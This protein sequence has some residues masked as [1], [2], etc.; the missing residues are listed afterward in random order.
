MSEK[1]YGLFAK[2]S[3]KKQIANLSKQNEKLVLFPPPQV[4]EAETDETLFENI[5]NFNWII[6]TDIFAADFFLQ[7][8]ERLETDLFDLDSVRVCAVGEAV[9]DR[10]RFVQ[11]HSDVIPA[12]SFPTNVY[13]A[14]REYVY[15]EEELKSLKF[16]I[17]CGHNTKSEISRVLKKNA[18]DV[19]EMP[20]YQMSFPENENL[21]KQKALLAGGAVDEF[22]FSSPEDVLYL[23]FLLQIENFTELNSDIRLKAGDRITSQTL[24]EFIN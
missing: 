6:F 5:S 8:A 21:P 13:S 23:K 24:S 17:I 1:T 10:L 14:L 12:K 2:E 9:A 11:V 22:V 15:E 7:K 19:T 3:S 18:I 20:V 4:T 16:L